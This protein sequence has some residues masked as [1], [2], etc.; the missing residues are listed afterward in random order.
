MSQLSNKGKILQKKDPSLGMLLRMNVRYAKD[1][2][3]E[4]AKLVLEIIYI[5]IY[6]T[7]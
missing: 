6:R 3:I 5:Y 4:T 1:I 7:N 2:S